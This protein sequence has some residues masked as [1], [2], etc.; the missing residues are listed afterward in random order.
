MGQLNIVQ[1]A[2]FKRETN[3]GGGDTG[4][5]YTKTEPTAANSLTA[6]NYVV[7]GDFKGK[8]KPKATF[9]NENCF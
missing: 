7:S 5:E 2:W 1:R 6:F 4:E 3:Y 8:I 9:A